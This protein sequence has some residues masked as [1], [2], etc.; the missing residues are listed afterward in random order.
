MQKFRTKSKA[1]MLHFFSF[2]CKKINQKLFRF[3]LNNLFFQNLFEKKR[4]Y[5]NFAPKF[6]KNDEILTYFRFL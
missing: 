4:R 5:F 3:F 1:K 6:K 2:F